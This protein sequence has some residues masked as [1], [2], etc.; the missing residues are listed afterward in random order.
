GAF[1]DV[2]TGRIVV[3]DVKQINGYNL[4]HNSRQLNKP[5]GKA[6]TIR[7]TPGK[8]VVSV[9]LDGLLE[10]LGGPFDK[11]LNYGEMRSALSLAIASEGWSSSSRRVRGNHL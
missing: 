5:G 2:S 8:F 1:T 11:Y 9:W 4:E 6:Q 7:R 10:S 3:E